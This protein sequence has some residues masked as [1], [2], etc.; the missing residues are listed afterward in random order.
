MTTGDLFPLTEVPP[1]AAKPPESGFLAT[2]HLNLM[3]M[4]G[5]GLAMPPAGFGEKYYRDTLESFPGWIP[6]F[7]GG[8]PKEVIEASV[9][10]ANH[11]KP[12]LVEFALSGMSGGIAV[13]TDNG[14]AKR[15]FPDECDGTERVLLV[16][17]PLPASAIE[18]IIFQSAKDR[19]ACE[20]DAEGFGNV[21]LGQ[22]KRRT[23]K[24]LFTRAPANPWPPADGPVERTVPLERPLAAGGA[25]AMLLRFGNLGEDAVRAC[26]DAFDPPDNSGQTPVEDPIMAGLASWMQSL[27]EAPPHQETDAAGIQSAVYARL[28]WSAAERLV[29]WRKSGRASSPESELLDQLD[30]AAVSLDPRAQAGV[31]KLR[32]TLESLTELADAPTSELFERHPTPLAHA[33]IL[34]FLRSDCTD[35]IDYR[36]ERL[37]EADWLA[38]AILFGIRDG[39]LNLPLV[40]RDH[41][42]LCDAVTHRMAQMSHRLA[43]TVMDLGVPPP[44]PRPLRERF[45]R[46]AA[47]RKA[48]RDAAL[49]LARVEKWDCVS[50]RISLSAGDY[51]LTIKSASI[52]IEVIGEPK[53]SPIIDAERFFERLAAARL[54]SGTEAKILARFRD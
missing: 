24:V 32:S 3:Y 25:M 30:K 22:F 26:R 16:P 44:R 37:E 1:S 6:L 38:A 42:G 13:F 51:K 45:G 27:Y 39:W 5:A 36:S 23:R 48:E 11:L 2:N 52:H 35:L 40:L 18:S 20:E 50:T 49:E 46:A 15:R 29:E 28:F 41:A 33:L 10:E 34:F 47:W 14:F 17:A 43:G 19:N 21:P 31:R 8:V 53:Y 7:V 54:D 9:R 12:V 4:L